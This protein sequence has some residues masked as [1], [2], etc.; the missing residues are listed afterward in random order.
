MITFFADSIWDEVTLLAK[1]ASNAGEVPVAAVILYQGKIIAKAH[2]AVER[3]HDATAHAEMLVMQ[4]AAQKLKIKTLN[5]CDL[6]VSLEPCAMCAGAI[7]H[8]R[9]RRLYF[10]AYDAK[11][12]AVENGIRLFQQPSCHHHPEVYGGIRESEYAV[13]LRDFFQIRRG[14]AT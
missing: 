7:A 13:L 12:G 1:A 9:I 14:E 4:E 6:Y 8:A 10:G 2:N 3:L 5:E 11:A